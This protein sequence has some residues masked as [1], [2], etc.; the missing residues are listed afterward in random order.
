M[1]GWGATRTLRAQLGVSAFAGTLPTLD[2][3]IE[4]TLDDGAT[5]NTIASFA[6]KAATGREVLNYTGLFG[7][8]LRVRWTIG[9]SAT[10]SFTFTVDCYS[11]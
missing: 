3:V 11:E 6:Q 2:V 7:E 5:W 4:D 1:I 10:P 8:T 9:G